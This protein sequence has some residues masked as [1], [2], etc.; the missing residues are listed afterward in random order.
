MTGEMSSHIYV[1][2][3]YI[4]FASICKFVHGFM[5]YSDSVLLKFFSLFVGLH[6]LSLNLFKSTFICI[7][8]QN[9]LTS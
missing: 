9:P 1:C 2:V 8:I 7:V 3:G 4:D 6:L 5:N